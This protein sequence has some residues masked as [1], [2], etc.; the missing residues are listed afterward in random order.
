MQISFFWDMTASSLVESYNVSD[1]TATT[2]IKQVYNIIHFITSPTFPEVLQ[3]HHF[4]SPYFL[5]SEPRITH[6]INM[7]FQ[8]VG[9]GGVG[10]IDVAQD[11]D[12]LRVLVNVVM[13]FRVP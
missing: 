7:D 9:W 4:H 10:L 1:E 3:Y 11:R 12:S 6:N 2:I 8:E 5:D 13:N